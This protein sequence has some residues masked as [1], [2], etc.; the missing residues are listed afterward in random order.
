MDVIIW[1]PDGKGGKGGK[2]AVE[3]DHEQETTNV[4]LGEMF[5]CDLLKCGVTVVQAEKSHQ[6][7]KLTQ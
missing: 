2:G 4:S 1:Q 3:W 5:I 6:V 7:S